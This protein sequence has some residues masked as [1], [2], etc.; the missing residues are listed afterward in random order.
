M[1][2]YELSSC[3]K[4]GSSEKDFLHMDESMTSATISPDGSRVATS[5]DVG[6]AVWDAVSGEKLLEADALGQLSAAFTPDGRVVLMDTYQ[7]PP[8]WE[9]G[10]KTAYRLPPYQG[11]NLR[12]AAFSPDGRWLSVSTYRG[13]VG[14][15][16]V[17]RA[18]GNGKANR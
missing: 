12:A 2:V 5:A 15:F 7:D 8:V 1:E 10:T 3:R 17:P 9:V 13:D 14:I 16:R 4:I 11:W 6:G 18:A